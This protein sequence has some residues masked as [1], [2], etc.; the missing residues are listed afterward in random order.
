MKRTII[1][2]CDGLFGRKCYCNNPKGEDVGCGKLYCQ[3]CGQTITVCDGCGK[4]FK[5]TMGDED[6]GGM[7]ADPLAETFCFWEEE[8]KHY[9]LNCKKELRTY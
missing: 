7:V 9:C 4:K 6:K 2:K 8:K 1:L 5:E 3:E